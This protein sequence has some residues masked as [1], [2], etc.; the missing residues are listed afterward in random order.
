MMTFPLGIALL[1]QE[2]RNM[3]MGTLLKIF[4][5]GAQVVMLAYL[6][7]TST[8]AGWLA[9]A[10]EILFIGLYFLI[11]AIRSRHAAKKEKGLVS[12]KNLILYGAGFLVL[13][14]LINLTSEGFRWTLPNAFERVAETIEQAKEIGN[15]LE[16]AGNLKAGNPRIPIYANSLE[17]GKDHFFLGV[18]IGNFYLKYP[19]Y[20]NTRA[21]SPAFSLNVKQHDVHN[22]YIQFFVEL[23][24]AGLLL[25]LSLFAVVF[26]LAWPFLWSET[27]P[28]RLVTLSIVVSAAGI[29]V[30]AFFSFPFQRAIPP[31]FLFILI[32]ILIKM[33][34]SYPTT[35]DKHSRTKNSAL[36]PRIKILSNLPLPVGIVASFAALVLIGT[37]GYLQIR[38]DYHFRIMYAAEKQK[39]PQT[40]LE[41]GFHVL[42]SNPFR[43]IVYSSTGR[44]KLALGYPE[45]AVDDIQHY[46]AFA[47]YDINALY[48]LG[49]AYYQLRLFPEAIESLA[50]VHQIKPDI[51][52]AHYLSGRAWLKLKEFE[53]AYDELSLAVGLNARNDVFW[54][55]LGL[56]A[57]YLY[58]F[59]DAQ[60]AFSKAV[61]LDPDKALN[62]FMLGNV[63]FRYL[64][65][66]KEGAEYLQNSLELN[67]KHPFAKTANNL[68][69]E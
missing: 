64:G 11:N 65:K 52:W 4:C 67:P 36:Q 53:E 59:E 12:S 24:I 28:N 27:G 23:G 21:F 6:F 34:P 57:L 37:L 3:I 31:L 66:K 22:D 25:F 15:Q 26:V 33:R 35:A 44:A 50:K 17:M 9:V 45:D 40:V 49:L 38:A 60:N 58:R 39:E 16:S 8:R 47:P 63:M 43:T 2:R 55:N 18:G 1:K 42:K 61:E 46:L 19:E 51:V 14:A 48:N 56:S 10:V 29:M 69:K 13:A 7:H 41:A 20:V 32:G 54:Y 62:H 30:D 5:V 68:L